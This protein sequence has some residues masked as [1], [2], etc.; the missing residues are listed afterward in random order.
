M[1][2]VL[3][4]LALVAGLSVHADAQKKILLNEDFS[5]VAVNYDD[6]YA[7]L[8]LQGWQVTSSEA[9]PA[10]P[11]KWCVYA[12]GKSNE[13][14][15]VAYIDRLYSSGVNQFSGV[16]YTPVLDLDDTYQ[17]SY[18]WEA[19]PAGLDSTHPYD[20]QVK[21]VEEGTDIADARILWDFTDPDM[22]LES[23]VAPNAYGQ[24]WSGWQFHTS[25]IDLSAWKGKKVRVAFLYKAN[26][27]RANCIMLDNVKVEQFDAAT[28][29]LA[30]FSA[31]SWNFGNVYIGSKMYSQIITLSNTGT[32]GLNVTSVEVPDGF[33]V[34][35]ERDLSTIGLKKNEEVKIQIS[36]TPTLTSA[37][38]G[39]VV[40]HGNFPDASINVSA[41]KKQVPAGG[42]FEGFEGDAFPP[43]GWTASKW[44]RTDAGIEGDHAAIPTAYYQEANYLQSPRIDCTKGAATIEF[45][46]ADF[47]YG[48][49]DG[50]ADTSVRLSFSSDGG[51]T[52]SVVDTYDY[53]D[54]YNEIIHKSYTRSANSDNCYWRFDWSLDYYDSELGA[55]AGLFYVDAI[56]LNNIY[57]AGGAPSQCDVS[58][59]ADGATGIYNRGLKLQWEPAQFATG[60]RLYVGTNAAATSLVNGQ[61]LGDAL[62]YELPQLDFN[63]TYFWKVVPYNA[64]G[65]ADNVP[66]WKFTTIS[67]PTVSALPWREGFDNGVPPAGWN[68]TS[69]G[70]S[71]WDKNEISP[72]DGTASAMANPR[73]QGTTTTLESPDVVLP[74]GTPAFASFYWGDGVAVS[75]IKPQEGIAEN[76]TKASDGISDL[77]FEIYSDGQWTRLALLS[78]KNNPY[79]IRERIDLTPYAG[80]RVAFRWVY[81]YYNYMKARGACVDNFSIELQS[82]EKLSFNVDGWDAGKMNFNDVFTTA[83][84]ISVINDGSADAEIASATF[85]SS[86][87]STSLKAGDIIPSGKALTFTVTADAADAG[88]VLDDALTITTKAGSTATFPVKAEVL[89]KDIRFFGFEDGKN[90][91]LT[92]K[93]LTFIDVDNKPTVGLGFVEYPHRGDKVAF[94]VINYTQNDWPNPYPRTGK[95]CLVTFGAY[96]NGEQEDW[97]IS[98]RMTATANSSFDFCG[99]NYEHK[100]NLGG[101]EVFGEGKATV[102]VSESVDPTDLNA[103]TAVKEHTL[104]YPVK[105]EY[106]EFTTD[107]SAYAG[108]KVFV[109]LRH[110]TVD[111]LAYLYDDFQ[112]NHFNDMELSGIENVTVDGSEI[113]VSVSDNAITVSVP[114]SIS[115]L[116]PSGAIMASAEGTSLDI[117]DLESGAYI[118]VAKSAAG[119]RSLKFIKR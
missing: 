115:V 58:N 51:A 92:V 22:L 40:F 75:L 35:A 70:T 104:P 27:D 52:W 47:Y 94:M 68:M 88:K 74:E 55:E 48:E 37:S 91:D 83:E 56:V 53:N 39:K 64:K 19:S 107:L 103:Y 33:G 26:N 109:A 100:D 72:Y 23:G 9:N 106:G 44:R 5:S 93:D 119:T 95:Q 41:T 11:M 80:K 63:T 20:F 108:K 59:P 17:L 81:T 2:K 62:S 118:A 86:N 98:P 113:A 4:S 7:P 42:V 84:I 54:T 38:Q 8:S 12:S 29:P 114:A 97:V 116:S 67:D 78:D 71:F 15:N 50:G 76:T 110:K 13:A 28:T 34:K 99:R 66:V 73:A 31:D 1:N 111:G 49:Q 87:F 10:L 16:L 85:G 117:T 25:K 30:T 21:V 65:S 112:Y 18:Q 77:A 57:G 43:A 90:G 96:D 105:D 6:H 60:Y 101:G 102:L 79:W 3:F 61:D 46:Y 69:D 36:Y 45:S 24:L 89:A 14:N 32:N 82:N